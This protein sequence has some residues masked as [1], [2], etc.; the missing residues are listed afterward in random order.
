MTIDA[1]LQE[2]LDHHEIRML[3]AEYC[4]GCDR[5]DEVQ[6]ASV[7]CEESWDDHGRV[8]ADGKAFSAQM[9]RELVDYASVCSHL[10]GQSLIRVQGDTA[11]AETYFLATVTYP[12]KASVNQLGGRY[13]DT[14]ERENGAWKIKKR[15]CIRDWSM[16]VPV[17]ADWLANDPF[18]G[19]SMSQNDPSYAALGLTH[20]GLP[21]RGEAAAYA[22]RG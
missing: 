12:G 10:L 15:I 14:L 5:G 21:K 11:G 22:E 17:E 13:V 18:V 1:R 2:L 6:M 7:Y 3:L 8:R 20:S 19:P 4:H 9:T 16:T